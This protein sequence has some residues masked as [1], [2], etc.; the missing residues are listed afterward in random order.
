MQTARKLAYKPKK[1]QAKANLRLITNDRKR[2]L[3]LSFLVLVFAIL[4]T[5][6][7]FNATQQTLVTQGAIEVE[8]LKNILEE[9]QTYNQKLIVE[10]A[11]LKS[12]ER[13]E[14]IALGKIGMILPSSVNYL[15]II[16]K[17]ISE[18]KL[19]MKNN[20]GGSFRD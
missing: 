14:K 2:G 10:V 1:E 18:S 11:K 7:M 6:V 9:E 8:N 12:P 19:A 17:K 3:S 16:D 4:P 5:S 20:D 15:K 13:I